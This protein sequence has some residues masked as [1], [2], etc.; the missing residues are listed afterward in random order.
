MPYPLSDKNRPDATLQRP[1]G[2]IHK[3]SR[4]KLLRASRMPWIWHETGYSRIVLTTAGTVANPKRSHNSAANTQKATWH[5]RTRS[6]IQNPTERV[7]KPPSILRDVPVRVDGVGPVSPFRTIP[8]SH[9]PRSVLPNIGARAPNLQSSAPPADN[10]FHA[11]PITPHAS[12]GNSEPDD[13]AGSPDAMSKC[14][15]PQS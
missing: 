3:L 7:A 4:H 15:Q 14:D 1:K 9:P 2:S 13:R 11:A 5:P 6:L 12:G 10:S 8:P